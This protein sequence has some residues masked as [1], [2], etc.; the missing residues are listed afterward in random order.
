M[1]DNLLLA[2]D[3]GTSAVKA[4]LVSPVRGGWKLHARAVRPLREPDSLPGGG[5]E[6]SP[7]EWWQAAVHAA[8]EVIEAVGASA[9]VRTVS[10][11]GQM[12][13]V[14]LCSRD[15]V[16]LRPALLYSDSRAS[17]EATHLEE[18]LGRERLLAETANWKGAVS[19]LPK[20][21]W[22]QRHEPDALES[23]VHVLL[24]AADYLFARLTRDGGDGSGDHRAP[25]APDALPALLTDYTNA[26]TTGLL[27]AAGG[28]WHD[29]LL[30]QAGLLSVRAKLPALA[31]P[32][33]A[34]LPLSTA[35]A[36]ALGIADGARVRV[37]HGAGDLGTT[38]VGALAA[39]G[40]ACS[41]TYCYLGTSG[42]VACAGAGAIDAPRA[43]GVRH[44]YAGH[45]IAAAP[46]TTAGAH[47][48][49]AGR[50]LFPEAKDEGSAIGMVEAEAK[51][52]APDAGG[53]L[54]L[55]YLGGERCPIEDP[56]ARACWIGMSAATRRPELCRAV[57]LG[58]CFALRSLLQL[59]PERPPLD[60]IASGSSANGSAIALVGGAARSH[61]LA[62]CL[63][64]VLQ[65]CIIVPAHPQ[66]IP[67][68]GCAEIAAEALGLRQT[69]EA[70][71][72][73]VR[74]GGVAFEATP[75]AAMAPSLDAM[76]QAF[77]GAH[78]GLRETFGTL[79]AAPRAQSNE[80]S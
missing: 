64:D 33:D 79:A 37:C 42:W 26:A 44:P 62:Q 22:L 43:F 28:D 71:A 59:L 31:A 67:A 1:S 2:L 80:Q 8:R 46:M 11:S 60:S 78:P 35:A 10:L 24:G 21:L 7:E 29:S 45:S 75:N 5:V 74:A 17:A 58:I 19:V 76:F 70:A 3:A 12:Q 69:S 30:E 39:L 51:C 25:P 77:C 49:W 52:A 18:Q 34:V 20:L 13:S 63:A 73:D 16:A 56:N 57:I 32:A 47:L 48:G 41:G 65:R 14:I 27:S 68:L 38:T 40:G 53:V 72:A 6:Q 4:L 54:F 23:A 61:V 15:A 55:P 9:D 50:L 66:D 36:A